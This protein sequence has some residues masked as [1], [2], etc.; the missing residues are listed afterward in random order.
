MA[1]TLRLAGKDVNRCPLP[2]TC[3][4]TAATN[5]PA[6]PCGPSPAAGRLRHHERHAYL[7]E[8]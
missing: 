7:G 8:S 6:P 1:G 5:G 2:F 4:N 3:G